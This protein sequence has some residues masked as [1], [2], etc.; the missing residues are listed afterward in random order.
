MHLK[1]FSASHLGQKVYFDLK[2]AKTKILCEYSGSLSDC[3]CCGFFVAIVKNVW[4]IQA[5][6][7][8]EGFCAIYVNV[9]IETTCSHTNLFKIVHSFL[10]TIVGGCEREV[11]WLV[12]DGTLLAFTLRQPVLVSTLSQKM[13]GRITEKGNRSPPNASWQMWDA[14]NLETKRTAA[15][16][17]AAFSLLW[18]FSR[19][20]CSANLRWV[21]HMQPVPLRQP[22]CHHMGTFLCFLP[23]VF[24]LV[25]IKQ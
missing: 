15:A 18:L 11:T 19:S 1:P 24:S 7:S 17:L 9:H 3:R 5:F 14:N 25:P 6:N 22:I 23:C 8:Q 13:D 10:S 2:F 4:A 12:Q 20:L 16:V 21:R